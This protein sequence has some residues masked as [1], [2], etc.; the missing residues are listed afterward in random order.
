MFKNS[1]VLALVVSLIATP[2]LAQINPNSPRALLEAGD[3]DGARSSLARLTAGDPKAA[4]HRMFLE[5]LILIHQSDPR[6]AA[7]VFRYILAI[8]PDYAPARRELSATLYVMGDSQAAKFH[9]EHLLALTSDERIRATA[10]AIIN[11]SQ[12]GKSL[13]VALRFAI[14][15]SSNQSKGTKADTVIVGGIPFTIDP[16][17]KAAAGTAVA[18]G[19]TVWRRWK[20]S[21]NWSGT[22]SL[23]FDAK[24]YA[25]AAPTELTLNPRFDFTH[26]SATTRF[27]FGP[28]MEIK[29]QSGATQR[30]RIGLNASF[31]AR[32]ADNQSVDLTM[33]AM[34]QSYPSQDHRNGWFVG[35]RLGLSHVVNPSLRLYLGVPFE[36]EK[37]RRA[38]LDHGKVGV[39][40]GLDKMWQGGLYTGL[41]ASFETDRYRA[42]FPGLSY[43]RRDIIQTV[44]LSIRHSKITLGSFT[45]ELT[46]SFTNQRS[47]V[48][49][50][51]YRSHDVSIGLSSSF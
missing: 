24:L 49:F 32:L 29:R 30:K 43:A 37:T 9:A 33:M 23:G 40:F 12:E 47:N 16:A 14:L 4:L 34:R 31:Q 10:Q 1:F 17:S 36:R 22:A 41:S 6:G 44:S 42:D 11:S 20:F 28:G 5:G 39:M 25:S 19:A 8:A 13:G 51:D 35:G 45:P 18:L 38:H 21:E 26:A 7:K 46:Y 48:A 15:P 3:F 50:F 2:C 27:S